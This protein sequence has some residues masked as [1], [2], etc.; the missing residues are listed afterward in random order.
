MCNFHV[1]SRRRQLL[2]MFHIKQPRRVS[3]NLAIF[4]I[5]EF[6]LKSLALMFWLTFPLFKAYQ[7]ESR[8]YSVIVQVANICLT[9]EFAYYFVVA[10]LR[11]E[12][13][14]KYHSELF[15]TVHGNV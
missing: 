13:G 3:D 11:G 10:K 4:M 9:G 6:C 15:H 5:C 1:D 2:Y 8:W 7:S 12:K 14:V